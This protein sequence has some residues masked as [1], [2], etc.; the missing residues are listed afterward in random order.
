MLKAVLMCKACTV[1]KSASQMF[2]HSP[3]KEG[4]YFVLPDSPYLL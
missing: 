4:K 2:L 3:T 1:Y